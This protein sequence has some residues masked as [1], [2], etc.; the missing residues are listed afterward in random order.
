MN[1]ST[2]SRPCSGI[3]S[4]TRFSPCP[5]FLYDLCVDLLLLPF[6]FQI[7]N[8]K[9]LLPCA[10][11]SAALS[12]PAYAQAPKPPAKQTQATR[13]RTP[14]PLQALLD[15]A[16][17]ALAEEQFAVAIAA[18][19]KFLAEQPDDPYAHFHLGY[20]HTGLKQWPQAIAA[21]RRATEL[22][23]DMAAAHLNLGLILYEHKSPA[24][25]IPS[26]RRASE[27]LANEARPH[28]LLGAALERSGK[29]AEAIVEYRAAAALD[30][31]DADTQLA[32]GRALLSTGKPANAEAAFRRAL[33]LDSQNSGARLGLAQ[34]LIEQKKPAQAAAELE[35]FL[36]AQPDNAE[37]WRQ[38]AT[39]HLESEDYEKA[40]AALDRADAVGQPPAAPSLLLRADIYQ[41]RHRID[42]AIATLAT[43]LQQQPQDASLHARLGRLHLE[44]R[45]FPAAERE[46]L[47]ALRLD[48]SSLD[49][50]RDLASVYYLA[51][52][53]DAALSVMDR[54]EQREPP[55]AFSWFIRATCYDKLLR[56]AEAVAAYEQFLALDDGR[57]PSRGIQARARVRT[58]KRELE[59]KP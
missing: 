38:L 21:Y 25:S 19:E 13:T 33:E 55:R 20:A 51:E 34:S 18:L 5:L 15:R 4:A 46:L 49:A 6:R 14:H 48:S 17:K 26:L 10:L 11:L 56:K 41:R 35:A 27:L 36:T 2:A 58:L 9:F 16:E 30:S 22:K 54:I 23:P 3:D 42:D 28:F 43:L 57:E 37:A 44:K 39:L 1:R 47:A 7:S 45:D 52:K 53:Y 40:L 31:R 24:A 32:L 50:L 12:L 59:N 8:P 29:H